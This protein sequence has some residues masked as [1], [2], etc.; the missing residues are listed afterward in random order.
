[1]ENKKN[2]MKQLQLQT[3]FQR[4]ETILWKVE[5]IHQFMTIQCLFDSPLPETIEG[6]RKEGEEKTLKREG[7]KKEEVEKLEKEQ[8]ERDREESWRKKRKEQKGWV[9][10]GR[11]KRK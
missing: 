9:K 11:K 1:M 6:K 5:T 7:K 4:N 8:K 2:F 3:N 10:N